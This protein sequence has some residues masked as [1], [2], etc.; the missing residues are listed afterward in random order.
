MEQWLERIIPAGPWHAGL[1][2]GA[3]AG[4]TVVIGLLIYLLLRWVALRAL[5]A[6]MN[7]LLAR[8]SRE[9]ETNVARLRTLEGLA[10]SSVTYLILFMALVTVLS[11]LGVNVAA[12]L[13]GAGVVGL[14]L[15]FGAQ[16]LV[17]DILSGVFL[18]LEDQFR[19]GEMVT[20]VG[21][22]GL[23]QFTGTI[24]EMG[25]RI[26]R[27][28]DL[29]GKLL[30]MGN[31]D[32]AVVVNHHRGPLKATV[33]VGLSPEASLD[34]ARSVIGETPL[35]DGLFTGAAEVEGV[36]SV[37]ADK[38]V[39]RVAAPSEPGKAPEAELILRQVLADALRKAELEIR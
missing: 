27:L 15:S 8:A 25:L 37:G 1:V 5:A 16:R 29:S 19:V 32:I 12:I 35:P 24:L 30:T 28:R 34:R 20:L 17:R 26:T 36:T 38:I 7:P 3:E 39:L 18:L 23:P 13:A 10:R 4:L 9:G 6:V 2:A 22:A 21:T 31:G 11:Q 14:A 33:E